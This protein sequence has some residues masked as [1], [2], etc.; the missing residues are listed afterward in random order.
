M[1]F[2]PKT[3]FVRLAFNLAIL[4]ALFNNSELMEDVCGS[5]TTPI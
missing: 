1:Q 3:I 5:F 4:Y 2:K